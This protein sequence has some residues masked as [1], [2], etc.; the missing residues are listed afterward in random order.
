MWAEQIQLEKENATAA[1][2]RA[3]KLQIDV[4]KYLGDIENKYKDIEKW[5]G[6]LRDSMS[7]CSNLKRNNAALQV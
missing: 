1:R 4:Q 3:D 2:E 5:K 6:K 7:E